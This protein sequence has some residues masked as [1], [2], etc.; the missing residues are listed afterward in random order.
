MAS[1]AFNIPVQDLAKAL[2]AAPS[3]RQS[4]WGNLTERANYLPFAPQMQRAPEDTTQVLT[5][6]EAQNVARVVA[7]GGHRL[8]PGE[9][10]LVPFMQALTQPVDS[11][12]IREVG[13]SAGPVIPLPVRGQPASVPTASIVESDLRT[14]AKRLAETRP[15]NEDG[16]TVDLRLDDLSTD[17]STLTG[18]ELEYCRRIRQ[19]YFPVTYTPQL[20]TEPFVVPLFRSTDGQV[21]AVLHREATMRL[22][23]GSRVYVNDMVDSKHIEVTVPRGARLVVNYDGLSTVKS[24]PAMSTAAGDVYKLAPGGGQI[25]CIK[26][27]APLDGGEPGLPR[28]LA[29]FGARMPTI[30]TGSRDVGPNA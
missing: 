13:P 21:A 3:Q 2:P 28:L 18:S 1:I 9:Q 19:K 24:E 17:P 6:A 12:E 10:Q 14:F 4:D 8:Y 11:R 16:N 25:V 20:S 27:V 29:V 5:H 23:Q 22:V 30:Q 26:V 7:E 15:G